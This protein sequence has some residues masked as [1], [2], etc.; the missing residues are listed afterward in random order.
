[1]NTEEWRREVEYCNRV[2]VS[3]NLSCFGGDWRHFRRYLM[4]QRRAATKQGA[5]NAIDGINHILR[6]LRDE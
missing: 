6:T 2:V 3:G 4:V 5:V 1:M